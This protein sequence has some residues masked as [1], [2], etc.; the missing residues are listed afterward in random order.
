M[1]NV[2]RPESIN[3][4]LDD[5]GGL[6]SVKEDIRAQVLVPLK[7]PD[8]FFGE[9]ESL[10]PPRG[11]LFYGPPGTGKTMLARAIAAEA[12]C[13]FVALSLSS[14]E[15]KWFGETSKL[16]GAT[17]SLARKLQ[18]CV[19]FFDEIDGMIRTRGDNDMSAVYGFKTEFLS[20]MDG[21]QT[22]QQDAFIVIA[23]TNCEKSLDPAIRRRLPQ[24]YKIDYPD[25]NEL[26]SILKVHLIKSGLKQEAIDAFA[27][28][29][30]DGAT[31]SDIH[32]LVKATWASQRKKM[33]MSEKFVKKLASGMMDAGT[34]ARKTGRM[35]LKSLIQT[36]SE[37][38][39]LSVSVSG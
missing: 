13:P 36:A 24:K 4:R 6:K 30:R 2:I 7:H 17:F 3:E 27:E 18:P 15:N 20:H 5:I 34:I 35:R 39:L 8:V 16:L 22:N 19:L 21:I 31:G 25:R 14:L 23:C 32:E 12:G 10:H 29:I 9:I 38:G 33:M 28:T 1:E 26:K 11:V 37:R